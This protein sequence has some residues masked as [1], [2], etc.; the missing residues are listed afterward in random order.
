MQDIENKKKNEIWN[1]PETVIDMAIKSDGRWFHEGGEITRPGLVR[2][3]ASVLRR[4]EDGSY[5]LVTPAECSRLEV[6][7]AP[8]VIVRMQRSD[9]PAGQLI[10]L[11]DN[12]ERR[13][14]LG[15]AHHLI[16]RPGHSPA[17]GRPYLMLAGGVEA[18][19]ARPVFY[20]LAELAEIGE[21][22]R[23]GVISGGV[24]FDLEL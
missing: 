7:D 1:L 22:G 11:F 9:R 23:S 3:F 20:E 5:W 15:P 8:F 17:E 18:L 21:N 19:I 24:F 14:D 13:Y 10:T 12:L 6:E 16:V 4:A 2:L